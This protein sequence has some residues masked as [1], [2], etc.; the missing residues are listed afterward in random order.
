MISED[1]TPPD[2]LQQSRTRGIL[3]SVI[4]VGPDDSGEADGI[5]YPVCV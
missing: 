2:P 1:Y 4:T 3:D 5:C